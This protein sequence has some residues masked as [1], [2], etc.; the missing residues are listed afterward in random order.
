MSLRVI[1]HYNWTWNIKSDNDV[2]IDSYAYLYAID[3]IKSII[4]SANRC[5]NNL[6][7]YITVSITI[8]FEKY[9]SY[10]VLHWAL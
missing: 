7:V 9:L 3:P 10:S 4:N 8:L 1:T 2:K 6:F 5:I